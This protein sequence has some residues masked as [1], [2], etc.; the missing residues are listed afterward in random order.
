MIHARTR[1]LKN[2]RIQRKQRIKQD[3]RAISFL[4][5]EEQLEQNIGSLLLL[6]I[7]SLF[8]RIVMQK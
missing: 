5:K 3:Q 7:L 4:S 1:S 6:L 8:L 2:L